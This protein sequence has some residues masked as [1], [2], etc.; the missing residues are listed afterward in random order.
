M[1]IQTR[2]KESIQNFSKLLESPPLI[3]NTEKAIRLIID[4]LK[5]NGKV[6]ICGNGGSAAD[7]QHFA[8]E[9]LCRFYKDRRPLACIALTTD[10]STLTAIANDYSYTEVF[11]R[12][13]EAL[14]KPEDILIGIS[15]SGSSKNVLEAF[16]VAK[17]KGLKTILLSG[18]KL[19]EIASLADLVINA[20]SSDTPRVQEMHLLIEHIICEEIERELF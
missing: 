6:L 19:K 15:T 12:Q 4:S 17:Q 1:N 2:I 8:G 13:V 10:T 18:E 3:Q 14:G 7:A 9:F 16:K 5:Q 20:P 11:S